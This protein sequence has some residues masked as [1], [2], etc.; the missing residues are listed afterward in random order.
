MQE[1]QPRNAGC[2]LASSRHG[3]EE[4]KAF[5]RACA[6][7]FGMATCGLTSTVV[8]VCCSVQVSMMAAIM[9][10]QNELQAFQKQGVIAVCG[11]LHAVAAAMP[12]A[13]PLSEQ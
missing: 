10:A 13:A 5:K 6:G 9:K 7:E 1:C 8:T 12:M 2:T 4:A 11:S 3:H